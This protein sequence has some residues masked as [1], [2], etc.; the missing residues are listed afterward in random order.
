MCCR[1]IKALKEALETA[2]EKRV[3]LAQDY[4]A[5]LGAVED[6]GRPED[7]DLVAQQ[8][9]E[10]AVCLS[11]PFSSSLLSSPSLL[12]SFVYFYALFTHFL[13]HSL[14]HSLLFP[15]LLRFYIFYL[16]PSLPHSLT[17][18]LP[19]S[20]TPSLP[21]SLTPSL[22]H[23]LTPSLFSFLFLYNSSLSLSLPS[24]SFHPFSKLIYYTA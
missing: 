20:L 3:R 9:E 1:D 10:D 19:H 8:L 12:L 7:D 6:E 24:F 23:S 18:S 22:P 15:L 2:D 16:T 21:H 4:L 14:L 11:S 5:R 17:P 13:Y